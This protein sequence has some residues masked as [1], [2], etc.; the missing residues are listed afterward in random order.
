[1]ISIRRMSL[2]AG[3]KYLMESVAAGDGDP[4]GSNGLSR[5]YAES[6]TPPGVFVGAGLAGLDDGNGV[7]AGSPVSEEQLFNMLGMCADP[8]TGRPLGRQPNRSHR[9]VAARVAR[10]LEGV[11]ASASADKRAEMVARIKAEE[12]ARA[13]GF[14]APVAGFDLTFSPPKSVSV[15]WAAGDEATRS[16]IYSCHRRAID[17]VLGYAEAEVF[18]SRSGTGGVVQEDIDGVVAVAFTHFDSRAGDPQLHDHVVVLNRARSSVDGKWRT[19]DSRGL[20]SAVVSLSELHQG[21]LSDLL[22]AELGWGWDSRARRHSDHPRFEV[23]GVPDAL[24]REFSQ[25]AEAIETGAGVLVERFVAAH[26]RQ[27]T[28]VE[29][30]RL[31]QQAALETRPDKCHRSLAEMTVEWRH[32]AR[33]YVGDEPEAWVASLQDRNDLPLLRASDLADEILADTASVTVQGVAERRATFCRANLLAEAHR[34]LHGVRFATPQERIRVAERTADLAVGQSL[35]LTVPELCHTPNRYRRPDGTSRLRPRG[36]EIYTTAT[37]LEAEARLL[38]AGR[39]LNGPAVT[40]T[41]V[42]TTIN[43]RRSGQ[44]SRLFADQTAAIEQ[45]ATSGRVL[46]VLV[47]PAGA[48]KSTAMAVL[49]TVWE[50][51][52]GPGSVV[53]LAPSAAAAEVLAGQLG[54]DTENT[55]KWLTEHRHHPDRLAQITTLRARLARLPVDS[56]GRRQLV[57]RLGRAQAEVARWQLNAGQLV[58]IDEASLAGTFALDELV[59]AACDA[60]AKVLVVGDPAQLSGVEAGG[61]FATLVADREGLAPELTDVRRFEHDWEK[62]ASLD[63]R[64]GRPEAIDAYQGHGRI[65][66]GE[67]SAMLDSLYRAWR[68]DVEAGLTSL[69]IAADLATVAKL[70]ARARGERVAAGLVAAHGVAIAGGDS[71]GVGDEVITRQNNRSLATGRRWVRNGDRWTVTATHPDGSIT[72]TR[73]K[74][75]GQVVLPA[76]YVGDHVELGYASSAYRAQGRTVDTAHALVSRTASREVLYVPW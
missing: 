60:G 61:M 7:E 13:G 22:T 49:R 37:L 17:I 36:H 32:R 27:P 16:V 42:V 39:Q 44:A 14:R 9:A 18:H 2:G 38:D 63:L 20:F 12:Q 29:A 74:G 54:V 5:Y 10:R 8:I 51:G 73:A 19:L 57:D 3:Y 35:R 11:G 52:H 23:T 46:D 53:G 47:G 72:V 15:T 34:Q 26:G 24:L 71:A 1:M 40:A 50:H 4:A 66:D 48:G 41:S 33:R 21:V 55:A 68:T 65:V 70:N 75:G 45:V 43:D 6:G 67:R 58:I 64:A 59:A 25:R 28:A 62:T 30:V 76:A 69:M 56:P 31:R